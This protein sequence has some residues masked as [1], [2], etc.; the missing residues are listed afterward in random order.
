MNDKLTV[1]LIAF[2]IPFPA[3]Y[4]GVI[5]VYYKITQLH[6]ANVSVILHCFYKDRILQKQLNTYCKEV[7]YYKRDLTKAHFSTL[8]YII[9]S[10]NSKALLNNL[11][12]DEHPIIFEGMHTCYLLDHPLLKTRKKIVRLHNIEHEYYNNLYRTEKNL[13]KKAFFRIEAFKLKSAIRKLSAASSFWAITPE[14]KDYFQKIFPQ[15]PTILLHPFTNPTKTTAKTGIGSYVL[16]HGNLSVPENID[17]AFFIVDQLSGKADLPIILAGKNPPDILL[18]A[19]KEKNVVIYSNPSD[20]EL[21]E[22]IRN[23][24]I[25]LV[26]SNYNCGLKLK[27]LTCLY[28]GRFCI[29]NSLIVQN[30]FVENL[31]IQANS[32]EEIVTVI[33]SLKNKEF[34]NADLENRNTILMQEYNI[35]L[36]TQKMIDTISKN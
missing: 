6:Q 36:E 7:Y 31:C 33:N 5:D 24:H 35:T 14:E 9:A 23:A 12:K 11:C 17:T 3:D 29:A 13:F 10:R 4:G 16:Y 18:K 32:A 34:S 28:H 27:L 8:P 15:V 21:N 30:T 22:L 2:D 19:A 25:N 26:Y 20:S 1:H